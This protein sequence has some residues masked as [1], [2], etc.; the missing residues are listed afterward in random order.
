MARQLLTLEP[1]PLYRAVM[2]Y[3][4]SGLHGLPLR[5]Y[6]D[7]DGQTYD[8]HRVYVFGPYEKPGP[9]KQAI[10]RGDSHTALGYRD[11]YDFTL[12]SGQ[13]VPYSVSESQGIVES[14]V[15]F[16]GLHG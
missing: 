12:P 1:E 7:R 8:Y 5:T 6:T 14:S 13:R 16:W 3:K 11:Y 10:K 4:Y 9:A 2:F 15:A